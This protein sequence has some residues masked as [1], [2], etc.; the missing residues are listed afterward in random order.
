MTPKMRALFFAVCMYS[1]RYRIAGVRPTADGYAQTIGSARA[2][3][4]PAELLNWSMLEIR[5][6]H[7]NTAGSV[8]RAINNIN[9]ILKRIMTRSSPSQPH[10]HEPSSLSG[11]DSR[12]ESGSE[13]ATADL[14]ITGRQCLWR[15]KAGDDEYTCTGSIKWFE[16]HSSV[17][18]LARTSRVR[19]ALSK[20]G[21]C[22]EKSKV[23]CESIESC[24]WRDEDKACG[25]DDGAKDALASSI[26]HLFDFSKENCGAAEW[27]WRNNALKETCDQGNE[28][29]HC[30][31][32]LGAGN[33]ACGVHETFTA[34]GRVGD[35]C[36]LIPKCVPLHPPSTGCKA[37]E[38][39]SKEAQH[40]ADEHNH[41]ASENDVKHRAWVACLKRHGCREVARLQEKEWQSV[42]K[43]RGL[44]DDE[45]SCQ[46]D[47]DCTF[48]TLLH[49]RAHCA[50][51][52]DSIYH[53]VTPAQCGL[54]SLFGL[55]VNCKKHRKDVC[56]GE[57]TWVEQHECE[58]NPESRDA[59]P[60]IGSVGL[61]SPKDSAWFSRYAEVSKNPD[62]SALAHI[63]QAEETCATF[64]DKAS[65]Q[66]AGLE[67]E[68]KSDKAKS[69]SKVTSSDDDSNESVGEEVQESDAAVS[70]SRFSS[71]VIPCFGGGIVV[72]FALYCYSQRP[73]H[74]QSWLPRGL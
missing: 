54:K 69:N 63:V 17:K 60:I 70:K 8:G 18:E 31:K 40:D 49:G 26:S 74:L 52:A 59:P 71:W 1:I 64:R 57:C 36:R 29:G 48:V 42:K 30:P 7:R 19:T 41:R 14:D 33:G 5:S 47:P 22:F 62:V 61:C 13:T 67:G 45:W 12:S 6:D 73:A 4:F 66:S 11:S 39:C 44:R 9:K 2:S 50:H 32:E 3:A 46:Q 27:V 43:C 58:T 38:K 20:L 72:A 16:N 28:I 65:C 55:Q 23:D 25:V 24:V 56:S 15:K 21:S 37:I 34:S 10:K 51:D 68:G 53:E 35:V